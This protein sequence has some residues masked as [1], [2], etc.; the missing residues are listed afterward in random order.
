V[1]SVPGGT[2][3]VAAPTTIS[4]T[5]GLG[6]IGV[7]ARGTSAST[8]TR[9]CVSAFAARYLMPRKPAPAEHLL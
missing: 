1:A 9:K 3:T 8:I 6:V 7:G 4:I 5:G 2:R